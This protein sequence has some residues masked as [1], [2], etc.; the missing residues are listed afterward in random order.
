MALSSRD[1]DGSPRLHEP[2]LRAIIRHAD[3]TAEMTALVLRNTRL[4]SSGSEGQPK[5]ELPAGFLLELAAAL[6]LGVWEH[7]GL[8]PH[9]PDGLPTFSQADAD[10]AARVS[11]DWE[12]MRAPEAAALSRRVLE[13]Y[14][15][16]FAWEGPELLGSDVV[17]G[18]VDEDAFVDALAEYVWSHRHELPTLLR[19]DKGHQ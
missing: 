14:V 9:L 11:E 15:E 12:A 13:L 19:T 1:G 6:Q 4:A 2:Q 3:F 7:E 17:V 16:R 8:R 5:A 10:L 18:D